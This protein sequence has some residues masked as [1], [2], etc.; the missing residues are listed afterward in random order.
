[1]VALVVF[2][3]PSF[4]F[5]LLLLPLVWFFRRYKKEEPFFLPFAS[6]WVGTERQGSINKLPVVC[7]YLAFVLFII[8]LAR[9]QEE[10][11][12]IPIRKEGYDIVLV[13]DISGSMLAED[14]EI[15]QKM[16]SRLDVVLDVVKAFLDKRVNDRIALVAF[17]GRAYTVCPLTFD[18]QWIKR[19][20]DQLQAGAIE[21]G[22]A[23]GD[24]LGLALSRLEGKKESEARHKIGSFL[25]LLTD[26][27]NNCGN[28]LPLEAAQ[29][30]ARSSIPVFAIGAGLSG[31][32]TMPVLD[33]ERR[34]IG[35]QT[36][37]SEVDEELL[38]KIAQLTGG[39][40]FRATDSNAILSAF[41]AID[42]KKKI[43][44]E[45]IVVTKKEELFPIFLV[46][47][48][49]FWFLAFLISKRI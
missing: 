14:Y 1:M 5:L 7:C 13:L 10:K 41:Q 29:L 24:A 2:A 32:V 16:V 17:A 8:A 25:I 35:S 39:E 28:L 21:D 43:P 31:E 18:H 42:T 33:E 26:G 20:I 3:N 9:P 27:A 38:R 12:K 48:L 36:V 22:T 40:Y 19:K 37:I 23:I 6:Q 46:L 45:P 34:K 49:F 44:F 4:F 30:A 11:G 15:D 47:G